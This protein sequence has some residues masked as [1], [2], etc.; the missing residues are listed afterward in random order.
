MPSQNDGKKNLAELSRIDRLTSSPVR[1]AVICAAVLVISASGGILIGK[2]F[3]A[4]KQPVELQV[5][6]ALAVPSLVIE[7]TEIVEIPAPESPFVHND[8]PPQLLKPLE[9]VKDPAL[10]DV[11]NVMVPSTEE[12]AWKRYAALSPPVEG[13]PMIA[14]VID[15][16]GLSQQKIEELNELPALLTI[17]FLP[18]SPSLQ[19]KVELVRRQGNEVMLHMPMEPTNHNIDPGPDAL[20]TTLSLDELRQRTIRNLD[21]FE[22][23]VGVNNHM[24]SRF[25]ADGEAMAVVMDIMAERG[26]LFLD[27][28]TTSASTGYRLAVERGMP[29]AKRD[30]FLDHVID[31]TAIL[32]QLAKVEAAAERSGVVIAIGHPHSATIRALHKWLPKAK[33]KGFLFVPISAVTAL[34][35]KG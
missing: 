27:S 16:V 23:Y 21:K 10:R 34:T 20:L 30:I 22:G 31:E 4:F 28:K 13:R 2:V 17:A 11:E 14:I 32:N 24:G 18:Y 33:E 5:V 3:N 19:G 35:F 25:T 9:P 6:S 8:Y 7:P 1:V 12:P 26:L 15:D 29:S